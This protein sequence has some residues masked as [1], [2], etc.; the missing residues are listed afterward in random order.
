MR[1]ENLTTTLRKTALGLTLYNQCIADGGRIPKETLEKRLKQ[2]QVEG[3]FKDCN[4][5]TFAKLCSLKEKALLEETNTC[6]DHLED[7]LDDIDD[8]YNS[9]VICKMVEY[10]DENGEI[11]GVIPLH[12]CGHEVHAQCMINFVKSWGKSTVCPQCRAIVLDEE[13]KVE[14]LLTLEERQARS[15]M[16]VDVSRNVMFPSVTREQLQ[17]QEQEAMQASRRR[18]LQRLREILEQD[19][20]SPM[21]RITTFLE[22]CRQMFRAGFPFKIEQ[23]RAGANSLESSALRDKARDLMQLYDEV[24]AEL[25]DEED[26]NT[27][28]YLEQKIDTLWYLRNLVRMLPDEDDVE[29]SLQNIKDEVE[30]DEWLATHLPE[31]VTEG[32]L[33]YLI[34]A[35]ENYVEDEDEKDEL[36]RV[37]RV[38]FGLQ[39]PH[40]EE[41][42][43]EERN[44]ELERLT[45]YYR[46]EKTR[47][48]DQDIGYTGLSQYL[49][50]EL[51]KA[52]EEGDDYM[53]NDRDIPR[54]MQ[55]GDLLTARDVM[56]DTDNDDLRNHVQNLMETRLGNNIEIHEEDGEESKLYV[57]LLLINYVRLL[58]DDRDWEEVVDL[59]VEKIEGWNM[60][61]A[62]NHQE[63]VIQEGVKDAITYLALG[64]NVYHVVKAAKALRGDATEIADY[65][66]DIKERY[67]PERDDQDVIQEYINDLADTS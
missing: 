60:H 43:S 14:N 3:H 35:I 57:T 58:T 2:L 33:E 59:M 12:P 29:D 62:R 36:Y 23:L 6:L 67:F 28:Q 13:F 55:L 4:V 17:R 9:C 53:I 64:G 26:R 42:G 61:Y 24:V 49:L 56:Y 19:E 48:E 7:E 15:S 54:S 25:E 20:E 46:E 1:N 50:V 38:A 30:D 27:K 63:D 40:I 66:T 52:Q 47:L 51:R 10:D 21:D 18:H 34:H 5:E 32:E 39:S 41:I 37:F 11:H 44:A 65:L 8:K 16:R 45:R 22:Y 31:V